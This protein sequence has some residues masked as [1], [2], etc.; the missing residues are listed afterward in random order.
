MDFTSDRFV[1]VPFE[2]SFSSENNVK[3]EQLQLYTVINDDFYFNII[4]K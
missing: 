2:I 1:D 4:K 3:S